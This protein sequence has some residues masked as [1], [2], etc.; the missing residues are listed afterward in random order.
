MPPQTNSHST[1]APLSISNAAEVERFRRLY[2]ENIGVDLDSVTAAR[3]LAD[4][5]QFY[6]LTRGHERYRFLH[7]EHPEQTRPEQTRTEAIHG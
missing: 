1:S 6:F 5:A 3:T 4:L 2:R 7:A